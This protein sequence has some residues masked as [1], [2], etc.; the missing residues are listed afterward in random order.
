MAGKK[1]LQ[2]KSLKR[3]TRVLKKTQNRLGRFFKQLAG[4]ELAI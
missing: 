2:K 1:T 4:K 3:H